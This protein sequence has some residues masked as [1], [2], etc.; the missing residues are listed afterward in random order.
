MAA[1]SGQKRA[2]L[3]LTPAYGIHQAGV[4]GRPLG[5][6]TVW[7]GKT[8]RAKSNPEV[9]GERAIEDVQAYVEAVSTDNL[10]KPFDPSQEVPYDS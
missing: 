9:S 8:Y 1:S 10:A 7:D 6:L 2:P 3:T 5:T 4:G